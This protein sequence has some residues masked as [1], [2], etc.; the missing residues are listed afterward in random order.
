ML[1]HVETNM[2]RCV[3]QPYWLT[4]SHLASTIDMKNVKAT[5]K[6]NINITVNSFVF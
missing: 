3:K 5:V 4:F 6:F 2:D 1:I